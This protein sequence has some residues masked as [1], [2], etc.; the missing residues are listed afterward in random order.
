MAATVLPALPARGRLLRILGVGFGV[1]V[2]VGSMIGTGILRTPGLVAGYLGTVWM[3]IAVWILG[4]IYALLC[5]SSVTELATMLPYAG[6]WYV[7][8]RR[9]FGERGGFVVGGCDAMAQSAS[10]AYLAAAFGEFAVGLYPPLSPHV[11]W[12]AAAAVATL[13]ILNWIGL[14][15][16]SRTQKLT[17]LAKA[18]G[19]IGLVVACF[20]LSAKY[21]GAPHL[22]AGLSGQ[23]PSLFLGWIL[24]LQGV[25]VTYDGWYAPIFFVEED[26]DPPRN[27]PRSIIGA[28]LSCTGIYLLVNAALLRVLGM[29]HLAGS[30]IPVADAALLLFGGYGKQVILLLSIVTVISCLNAG[31]LFTPR[32][33]FAMA[34]NA[35]L[36]RRVSSVN[37]GGTP[38]IA[39]FLCAC[40]AIALVLS[41]S[42]ETLIAIGS[43]L[44]VAVYL[45][46]FIS[47]LVLRQ[48]EP[49]LPRPYK[50]WLYPWSTLFVVLASAAFLLGAVLADLRHALFTIIVVLVGLIASLLV[51]P[52]RLL[53][54]PRESK[55]L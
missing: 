48:R 17:S 21:P 5:S 3:V 40:V 43:I 41:G 38:T 23:K 30:Q 50:A 35:M 25:V 45:S 37:R 33:L 36:P 19:L 24:A 8:S 4:G 14:K 1:A 34:R 20:T 11:R 52:R 7:Y 42:F 22:A 54:D 51:V 9:A 39:L 46:G 29:D 18:L 15:T 13:A 31:L 49:L 44:V 32:I 47:L 10:N 26:Q 6:G 16:G 53:P 28:V 27:L 12:V 2:G 55:G